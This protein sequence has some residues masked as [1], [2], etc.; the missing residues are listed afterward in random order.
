MLMFWLIKNVS[1]WTRQESE[2]YKNTEIHIPDGK[3]LS[4]EQRETKT[5][6]PEN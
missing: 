5:L 1:Y 2:S 4:L 3:H 6:Q